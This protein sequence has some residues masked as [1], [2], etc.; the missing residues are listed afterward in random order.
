MKVHGIGCANHNFFEGFLGRMPHG[1]RRSTNIVPIVGDFIVQ[2][3]RPVNL[4]KL[5]IFAQQDTYTT[6]LKI[7]SEHSSGLFEEA[8]RKV[9]ARQDSGAC[10]DAKQCVSQPDGRI[11]VRGRLDR[12]WHKQ[13]CR[14]H[15]G[16]P[17][18]PTWPSTKT[19]P[20]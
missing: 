1:L 19:H 3:L 14:L 20:P 16:L 6:S 15:V 12:H 18:F 2:P 11:R 5:K 7:A 13:T 8:D 4:S 9:V 10:G 17:T